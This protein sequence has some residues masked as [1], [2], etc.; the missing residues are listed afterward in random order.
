MHTLKVEY[1]L[2]VSISY[3]LNRIKQFS[4]NILSSSTLNHFNILYVTNLLLSL[5]EFDGLVFGLPEYQ[6]RNFLPLC[7]KVD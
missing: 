5:Q 6:R 4:A 2:V 7:L 1:I 3:V